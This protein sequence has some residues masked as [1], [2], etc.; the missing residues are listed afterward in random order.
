MF[1]DIRGKWW[2]TKYCSMKDHGLGGADV[3]V[4]C[5]EERERVL[6]DVEAL[7]LKGVRS[8]GKPA[9]KRGRDCMNN[10]QLQLGIEI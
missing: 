1:V 3:F 8:T 4:W 6:R 2:G 9:E 10:L 5:V 7:Q